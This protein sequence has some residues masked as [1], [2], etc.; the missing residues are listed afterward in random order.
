MRREV[1]GYF[2]MERL[3]GEEY[4]RGA[5]RVNLGR[6]ALVCWMRARGLRRIC[7]PQFLCSSVIETCLDEG[8]EISYYPV[9]YDFLPVGDVSCSDDQAYYLVNYYGQV[10]DDT[11]KQFARQV[12]HLIVD[13]THDFFRRPV[14]SIPA[15]YS[16][17]KY[18][19]LPDGAY[20]FCDDDI[21]IDETDCSYERMRHILGRYEKDAS[22]FYQDMLATS[23]T[24]NH[25]TPKAMSRLTENLLRGIDYSFVQSRRESNFDVL[26]GILGGY[27]RLDIVRPSGPFCYPLMVEDGVALRKELAARGI[28]VPTYWANVIDQMPETSVE[29][30]LAANILALPCDQRYGQEDMEYVAAEVESLLNG[31]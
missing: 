11:M 28:Y 9:G 24:F 15:L 2:Q 8:Y 22:T 27:N 1:G 17:R 12:K 4:H 30:R 26:A 10:S 14:E 21:E 7:L 29:H 3:S 13:N 6:T 5:L 20:L 16:C 23:R 19:G 18:F 25:A 31:R